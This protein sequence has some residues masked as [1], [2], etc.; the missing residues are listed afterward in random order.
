MFSMFSDP[1]LQHDETLSKDSDTRTHLLYF[2]HAKK[3]LFASHEI[4]CV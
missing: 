3:Y 1:P 4:D 2:S